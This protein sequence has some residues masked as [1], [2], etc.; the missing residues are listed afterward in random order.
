MTKP[1]HIP[2]L[3]DEILQFIADMPGR[4]A[5]GLDVTFG[6]GGHT[7]AF[8]ERFSELKMTGL[9]RDQAAIDYGRL[10]FSSLLDSG[11]LSLAKQNFHEGIPAQ[12][13]GWDFILADLGVSSPQLDE[14]TRGFSFYQDGPLDMRMDQSQLLTAAQIV[15]EWSAEE[16]SNLF[17]DLGEIRRPN[18]VVAR[19]IEQ[20]REQPFTTTQQLSQLIERSEG[21]QRRG[22][23]PATQYFLALRLEVNQELSA[24]RPAVEALMPS[25]RPGGRL[26]VITFHSLEDRIIKYAFKESTL[27]RPVNKKVV[28]PSRAEEVSNPRARSAKL[29]VFER[30]NAT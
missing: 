21:W 29:R 25:L 10:Q 11:R 2:V 7:S 13:G 28:M 20:R 8:L 19:M 6:R 27:G 23:H 26:L 1:L 24:L 14:A 4:H 18:R 9:D 15:N 16:L 22:H 12:E 3:C 30:G 5:Y 17:H